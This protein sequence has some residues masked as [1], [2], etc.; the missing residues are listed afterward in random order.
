LSWNL[1]GEKEE[2]VEIRYTLSL[3]LRLAMDM[4]ATLPLE[5]S[6]QPRQSIGG[7]LQPSKWRDLD[8]N[9]SSNTHDQLQPALVSWIPS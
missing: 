1:L 4:M 6:A 9:F 3:K 8:A 5:D 2:G 7:M